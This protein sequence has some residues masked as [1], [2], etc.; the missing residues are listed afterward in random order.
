MD[1]KIARFVYEPIMARAVFFNEIGQEIMSGL[2][3]WEAFGD[4]PFIKLRNRFL[5]EDTAVRYEKQVREFIRNG[6]KGD[7]L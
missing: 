3:D 6:Q 7:L 4:I 2:V 1:E 5:D